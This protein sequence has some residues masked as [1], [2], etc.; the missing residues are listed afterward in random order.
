MSNVLQ[1]HFTDRRDAIVFA[2]APALMAFWKQFVNLET[3]AYYYQ[4]RLKLSDQE[5]RA[6]CDRRIAESRRNAP[7]NRAA[8]SAA[9]KTRGIVLASHDD[10]TA[11]HVDEAVAQGIRVA[12]FPTTHEA[13]R[14]SRDAGLG[15]LMGAP[16]VVR[17]GSHSGNVSARALAEDGLL[18]ILSSDYIPFSLIQSAFFLGSVV[19]GELNGNPTANADGDDLVFA[20]DGAYQNAKNQHG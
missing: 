17:G 14:A 9:C 11:A 5:F 16:N 13:A 4:R 6:F 12:E 10:A 20:V 2:A 3:Y 8:I 19:D 18:D 7:P 1:Q 15:V